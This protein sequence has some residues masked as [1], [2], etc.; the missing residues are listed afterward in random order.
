MLANYVPV[1][2]FLG[3]STVLAAALLG[4]GA[5]F[6]SLGARGPRPG[7]G[8]GARQPLTFCSP[9]WWNW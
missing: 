9:T 3:L 5:L 6:G 1:L 4:L 8:Q 7:H 2:I